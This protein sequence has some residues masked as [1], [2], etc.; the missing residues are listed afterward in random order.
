MCDLGDFRYGQPSHMALINGIADMDSQHPL[1]NGVELPEPTVWPGSLAFAK[2]DSNHEKKCR[3]LTELLIRNMDT[4]AVVRDEI[5]FVLGAI[6]FQSS[7]PTKDDFAEAKRS[8]T[9]FQDLLGELHDDDRKLA[10][11]SEALLSFSV[12]AI[13]MNVKWAAKEQAA[14]K[15]AAQEAEDDAEFWQNVNDGAFDDL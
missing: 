11:W 14:K 13:G 9:R 3:I 5:F 6:K 4:M 8:Q 10:V 12:M 2:I 1:L 7:Q 15:A